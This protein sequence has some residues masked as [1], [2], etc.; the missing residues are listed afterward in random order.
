MVFDS[1]EEYES[2]VSQIVVESSYGDDLSGESASSETV[3]SQDIPQKKPKDPDE[4]A[5]I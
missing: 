5:N 3:S 4:G 1:S 2:S